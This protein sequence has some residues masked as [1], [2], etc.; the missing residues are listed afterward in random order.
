MRGGFFL[1]SIA[2]VCLL[3]V[4]QPRAFAAD[5]SILDSLG[6]HTA[7][8]ASGRY[9]E[10]ERTS[11]F[12]HGYDYGSD[13]M[14]H[15]IRLILNGGFGILQVGNRDNSLDEIDFETGAENVYDNLRYP[16]KAIREEGFSEF[17]TTQ[18]LP[19]SVNG[20]KAYYWPNYTL[21]LLGGGMSY[22]MM[23]EW[24]E[25]HRFP[26]PTL[27]ALLTLSVYHL[28]NE[29]VENSAFVGYNTDPIADMYI[30]NPA[31][32]LLFS[33]DR[34]SRF[35]SHT[36]N[37]VDWSFQVAYDPWDNSIENVGQNFAMK[38][39]FGSRERY[40]VFYHFGNHGEVG[41]SIRR[42]NGECFSFG[43]G[44][45]TNE[46]VDL[47]DDTNLR[48][49]AADLVP[50]AGIFYDRNN[51]LLASLIY[52]KKQDYTLRLNIYPGLLDV[53]GFSPGVFVAVD[54]DDRMM[55]GI[56]LSYIPIG[57]SGSF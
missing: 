56:T 10:S 50:S 54:Q 2:M 35:F 42:E 41:L 29:V 1:V 26:H 52:S 6:V 34:V 31:G 16:F 19:F 36:M 14:I 22:R 9:E 24:F 45:I 38:Y 5:V 39:F 13:R 55:A 17:V 11:F 53:K 18:I 48:S 51:S 4:Y 43:A 8:A 32:I 15:P 27:H 7:P 49:L 47:S 25:A 57:L 23:E 44:L 33:S 40:G 37:L 20:G 3:S 28:L 30:F 46:L 12:Y 21:H